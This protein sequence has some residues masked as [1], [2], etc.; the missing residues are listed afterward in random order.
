MLKMLLFDVDGVLVL[1][2]EPFTYHLERDHGI[3]REKTRPFFKKTFANFLMGQTD[4]KME[5]APYLQEWGWQQSVNDFLQYWFVSEHNID[6][7]LVEHIQHLRHKGIPCYLAT[8]QEQYRAAY[9]MK[10]MGFADKF[11]GI[12]FSAHVGYMKPQTEFFEHVLR[13]M[14]PILPHE[15]LFWDDRPENVD[16]ARQAGMLA[17]VY[18]NFVDFQR[19]MGE[20]AFFPLK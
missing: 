10:E 12:F 3:T 13:K 5:L 20:F 7:P 11:D 1:N 4:L 2:A 19:K 18:T 17:E 8:N 9:I 14:D 6:K 16:S 15:M